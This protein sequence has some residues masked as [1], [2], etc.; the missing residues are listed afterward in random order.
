L[1]VSDK[2]FC[3]FVCLENK[4]HSSTH[5][6]IDED[7]I[8]SG[9]WPANWSLASYEDVGEYYAGQVLKEQ[10]QNNVSGVM[11]T[12]ILTAEPTSSVEVS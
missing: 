5:R 3:L 10:E 1:P 8:P 2:R 12:N 11:T 6:Q 9:E 7:V 4:P